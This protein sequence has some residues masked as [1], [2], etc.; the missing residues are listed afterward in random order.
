[1]DYLV[2]LPFNEDKSQAKKVTMFDWISKLFK[3]NP[4][5]TDTPFVEPKKRSD[6]DFMTQALIF[7]SATQALRP[8]ISSDHSDEGS[9]DGGS[10]A[11]D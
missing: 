11:G 8:D 10:S 1:M 3:S 2:V 6:D 9:S 7:P 5:E 4:N